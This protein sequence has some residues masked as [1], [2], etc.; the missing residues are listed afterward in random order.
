MSKASDYRQE[1][2][3]EII[4]LLEKGTAPWQSG[5]QFNDSRVFDRPY[6]PNSEKAYRGMN[7]L[8]LS[9]VSHKK[10]YTEHRW[11]TFKQAND[12]GWRIKAGE[13]G[14]IVEFWKFTEK[15][16]IID[17]DGSKVMEEV[18]LARPM[19]IRS[20]VFD[21]EQ[22]TGVPPLEK[23]TPNL[24]EAK[25]R[26]EKILEN[27]GASIEHRANI[28]PHYNVLD[29]KIFLPEKTQYKNA[30]SYYATALHELGHW[31]GAESRL[32]RS[33]L[34]GFGTEDYAKEELRAELASYFMAT[35]IG[36][37]NILTDG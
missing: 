24:W 25:S 11:C 13:H 32:N 10:G 12:K 8:Y 2:T 15:R 22:M 34:N 6:N 17:K 26:A 16:E 3:N 18:S 14:K 7:S 21:V 1:L 30:E 35:E 23:N 5:W 27:S 28:T 9:I 31:T 20:V 33:I 4:E 36:I 37:P 19:I 29:D